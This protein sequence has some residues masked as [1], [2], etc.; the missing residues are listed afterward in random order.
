MPKATNNSSG[1]SAYNETLVAQEITQQR[2]GSDYVIIF[3]HY[4]NEYSRTPNKNG[5]IFHQCIDNGR[6]CL[7]SIHM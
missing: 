6:Y 2:N 4:G 1:Y 7:G 3:M 5:E